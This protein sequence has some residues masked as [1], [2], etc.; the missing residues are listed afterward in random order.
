VA[1]SDFFNF[2]QIH[3]LESKRVSL[4][5]DSKPGAPVVSYKVLI[6]TG[7]RRGGGTDANA[8]LTIYGTEGDSGEHKLESS[9]RNFE[10]N[11]TDTFGFEFVDLG[12]IQKIK[13]R[14][15]NSGVSSGWFL[16][17]VVIDSGNGERF[18]SHLASGYP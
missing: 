3:G 2:S 11:Q 9:G 12:E 4:F 16:N 5:E 7:D 17:K 18:T 6:T 10:R 14:H 8:F 13:I 1:N 15:D